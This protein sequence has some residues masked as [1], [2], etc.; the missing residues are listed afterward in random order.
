M[1]AYASDMPAEN[2]DYYSEI[3]IEIDGWTWN[4]EEHVHFPSAERL[5]A[6]WQREN[7]KDAA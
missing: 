7:E 4:V 5:L 6:D 1:N 2:E 3:D